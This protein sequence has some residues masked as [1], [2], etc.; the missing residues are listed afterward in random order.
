MPWL[1][2]ACIVQLRSWD[3]QLT[4]WS[5]EWCT[6]QH[7]K[8]TTGFLGSCLFARTLWLFVYMLLLSLPCLPWHFLAVPAYNAQLMEP[9]TFVCCFCC[10]FRH[11]FPDS[12]LFVVVVVSNLDTFSWIYC[13]CWYHEQLKPR[14]HDVVSMI[15]L[16]MSFK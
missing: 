9:R 1:S 16:K 6:E 14:N 11:L 8:I 5:A 10:W 2:I 13:C 3:D 15:V 12:F 4:E 7:C